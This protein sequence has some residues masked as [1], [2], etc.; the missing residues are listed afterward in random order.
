MLMDIYL[1]RHTEVAVGRSIAYGQSDVALA[2]T[3]DEQYGRLRQHLPEE[4]VTLFSSPLSRCRRL[5]EV[6]AAS[7]ESGSRIRQSGRSPLLKVGWKLKAL[8]G[9]PS[10][11]IASIRPWP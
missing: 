7:L 9:N 6:L 10:R 11:T 3:Y 4:P 2:D 1:I 5:A 8:A